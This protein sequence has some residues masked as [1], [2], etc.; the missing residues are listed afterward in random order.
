M[1]NNKPGFFA[2]NRASDGY[3]LKRKMATWFTTCFR[4][5]LLFGLCFLILQP[6]FYQFS[7]SVMGEND[8]YDATII[9]IPRNFTWGNF[10]LANQLMN[11]WTSLFRTVLI[12]L[13][14]ATLQIA[15]CT[16]TA[17][18]FA[19]FKFPFKRLC[20]ALVLITIIVPPRVILAPLF[21]NF[22]F[23]DV[24]GIFALINGE[25]LNLLDTVAGYLVLVGMGMG[26]RSGLYV[27][28]LRQH[29]RNMP[30]DLEEAAYIDGCGR[31]RTFVQIMLPDAKPMLL[32]CFLFAFVWQWTDA[33]YT[34][35]FLNP[36]GVLSAQMSSL[37]EGYVAYLVTG[38]ATGTAV[39]PAMI[40]QMIS[41]GLLMGVAPIILIYLF[42]QRF[43]VESISQSG[44]KM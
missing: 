7:L 11:Y 21:M 41:T 8:L 26:L 29:F 27:Y 44:L 17:Y 28:M 37:G 36:L 18:G 35:L 15:T 30:K 31:L 24:L 34:N 10:I 14:V 9:L 16:L 23:F 3:L 4:A 2:R 32:S 42:A 38:V 25:P 13:V 20:F 12:S 22:R 1:I 19:R 43:F 40:Q 6:L 33:F 39:P 5:L